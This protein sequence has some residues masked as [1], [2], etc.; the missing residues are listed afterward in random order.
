[1]RDKK[2]RTSEMCMYVRAQ[3]LCSIHDASSHSTLEHVVQSKALHSG[4]S[5]PALREY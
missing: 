2:Q 4:R 3:S 5:A 1:M